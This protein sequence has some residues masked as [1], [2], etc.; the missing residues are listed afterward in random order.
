MPRRKAV[1]N[2]QPDFIERRVVVTTPTSYAARSFMEPT[3]TY[4]QRV[5]KLNKNR[6]TTDD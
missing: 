2:P 3:K 6:V 1:K 4:K 5:A